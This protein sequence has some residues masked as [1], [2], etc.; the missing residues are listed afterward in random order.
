LLGSEHT[1]ESF[2][3]FTEKSRLFFSQSDYRLQSDAGLFIAE[4]T[5][6]P[7]CFSSTGQP[8]P[9]LPLLQGQ[10]LSSLAEPLNKVTELSSLL[11]TQSELISD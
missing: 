6:L 9:G 7:D 2:L 4:L 3:L 1:G 5:A 8:T 10:F 11:I